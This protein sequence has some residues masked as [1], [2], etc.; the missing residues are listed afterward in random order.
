MTGQAMP[1]RLAPFV[2]RSR[3]LLIDLDSRLS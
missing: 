1:D 3:C 2:W